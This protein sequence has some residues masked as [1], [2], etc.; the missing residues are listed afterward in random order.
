M[1]TTKQL[2][3]EKGSKEAEFRAL[4]EK[5]E[6]K[7]EITKEDKELRTSI[8]D[9]IEALNEEIEA[10]KR[11]DDLTK[12]L[13][14]VAGSGVQ[15]DIKEEK[16]ISQRF[17]MAKA[18]RALAGQG[19]LEG[20]EKEM[21]QEGINEAREAGVEYGGARIVIPSKFVE[22]RTDID[23][24]TSVIQPTTVGNYTNALR[25]NAVYANVPGINVYDGLMGDM[26]LP[27]TAK[28]TL[29][30]ATAENSAAA[31]GG[32]NFTKDTLAPVRLTGY[33]DISNRVLAQNGNAAMTAVMTDLGRSEAEL[34]N[35]AM[36]STTSVTNA[37]GALA[38]TSGVLTMTETATYA[39]GTSV[40]KD[41][42]LALR[43]VANDH[44]LTGN[45]AYVG[46]TELIADIL[47][48]V[49]V[50]GITPTVTAGGYNRYTIN[51]MNAFFS[52]GNTKV[53][54]TSGDAIFGDFSRVHFGRWGGLNI[55]VDP[56]TVAGNDQ[57]RLVV[58]SNVD[59]SLVQGAA[60]VKYTSLTA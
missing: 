24:T 2:L 55:L 50:A 29:A 14:S 51:G 10:Q 44:G 34:I 47:A 42:L 17:D 4:Q 31:D 39:Y 1:K 25:E 5:Y 21:I 23:Q 37:P 19:K 43:A 3:E 58:N 15:T 8:I 6:G 40:A 32:A 26:K 45:H 46:S 16:Q 30:W 52:T 13:A 18:V 56:Y 12:K 38:A 35:T 9:S 49:N 36:F 57:I 20:A 53:A 22:K 60:F 41:Y 7:L 27:V 28:Q 59:W 48:G 54:G 33:V 11:A